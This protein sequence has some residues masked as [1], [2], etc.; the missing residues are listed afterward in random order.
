MKKKILLLAVV[1]LLTA[2]CGKVPKLASGEELVVSF[3]NEKLAITAD[4]L[5][6]ELKEKYAIN[7]LIDLI[8]NQILLDK[9]PKK[10]EEAKEYVKDQLDD[11]KEYYVDDKGKYDEEALLEA[12][13]SYYGIS[14]IEAFEEMLTLN[15]YRTLAIEDYA[16]AQVKDKDIKNYYKNDVYGEIE[17]KHILISSKATEDMTDKEKEAA[18]KEALK[19]AEDIIKKLDKG[20]KFDELAKKHSDDKSNAEKGG[21]LGY[22]GKGKMVAAFETAV[23]ALKVDEYSKKPVKTEFGYHI[24]LKTD[25]LEKPSLEDSEKEIRE[26]LG[27]EIQSKD[28]TISVNALADLRKEYGFKINDSSLDS[29]YTRLISNQLLSLRQQTN[30]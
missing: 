18:D 13:K 20:E 12:L 19:L 23:Y 14:T 11:I 22:F 4:D 10:D 29:Q 6:N 2:G 26:T 15:Y 24:I 21:D 7:I 1:V 28:N 8:D 16:K 3:K 17:A 27:K 30:E 5:F 25:E 9:Y